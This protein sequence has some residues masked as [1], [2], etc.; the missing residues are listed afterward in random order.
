MTA[1]NTFSTVD[2]AASASLNVL[3]RGSCPR[4]VDDPPVRRIWTGSARLKWGLGHV[5]LAS[6]PPADADPP[7]VMAAN[8]PLEVVDEEFAFSRG[9]TVSCPSRCT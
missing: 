7:A 8:L 2:A 1:T 9:S 4:P 3:S 6:A 5:C